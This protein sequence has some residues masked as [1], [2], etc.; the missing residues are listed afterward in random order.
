MAN[1][2][3]KKNRREFF[4]RLGM[5]IAI[6]AVIAIVYN[7][8]NGL[9]K[10]KV[11]SEHEFFQYLYGKKLEYTGILEMSDKDNITKFET[12]EGTIYLESIPVYYK[13]EKFKAILPEDMAVVFP[14]E[15]GVTNKLNS[16][17]TAYI[18]YDDVYLKKGSLNK[19][20]EN[21]FLYDGNDL[22]FFI[23]NTIVNVDGQE[24]KLPPLSYVN[25]TYRGYV[26]IYNYDTDEYTYIE[27]V[28]E[29]VTAKTT[30]YTINLS[31]DT[32]KYEE[33]E[34]ILLKRIKNLTN[35]END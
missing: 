17:S 8:I 11:N 19:K 25:A 22:Y 23:E 10:I 5:I 24:Y 29:D 14:V 26:E 12:K 9:Q 35:L 18:K 7:Y 30:Y 34:Q 20:I 32:V 31:N 13:D 21:A 3:K 4:I 1:K 27:E 15:G 33:N 28:N 16:L 2:A 6:L